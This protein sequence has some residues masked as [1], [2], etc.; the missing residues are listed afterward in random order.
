[1]TA[2]PRDSLPL[3]RPLFCRP[4]TTPGTRATSPLPSPPPPPRHLQCCGALPVVMAGAASTLRCGGGG[5]GPL[6]VRI[7][8]SFVVG[9]KSTRIACKERM[10]IDDAMHSFR[11]NSP[12][13]HPPPLSLQS[14]SCSQR[15]ARSQDPSHPGYR[16]RSWL[17]SITRRLHELPALHKY[18]CSIC[19]LS[20]RK[21]PHPVT[22]LVR[23][24]D[25]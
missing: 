17:E 10:I 7:L 21:L 16:A 25:H 19:Q 22:P 6:K 12:F 1:M 11:T 9:I 3:H 5:H 15:R 13:I 20:L 4:R 14:A 8:Q 23:T 2:K 18:S 24:S